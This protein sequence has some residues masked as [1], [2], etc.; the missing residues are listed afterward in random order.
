MMVKEYN[1]HMAILTWIKTF[2][3]KNSLGIVL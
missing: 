1:N 2:F 3:M